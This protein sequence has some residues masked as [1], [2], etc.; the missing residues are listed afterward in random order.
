MVAACLTPVDSFRGSHRNTCWGPSVFCSDCSLGL[1][2][3]IS[4]SLYNVTE[5]PHLLT[6][7]N[8][9][10]SVLWVDQVSAPD[11]GSIS[12]CCFEGTYL[13]WTTQCPARHACSHD[14]GQLL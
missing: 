8:Q 2:T 14:A 5:P 12:A 13:T 9:L 4:V 3:A 11:S 1:R 6:V 10:N 7:L